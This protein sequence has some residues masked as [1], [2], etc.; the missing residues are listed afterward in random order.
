MRNTKVVMPVLGMFIVVVASAIESSA[1]SPV[2]GSRVAVPR[3]PAAS[4]LFPGIYDENGCRVLPQD[5]GGGRICPPKGQRRAERR[6]AARAARGNATVNRRGFRGPFYATSTSG[7]GVVVLES[8]VMSTTTGTWRA[9]GLLRNDTSED[10]AGIRVA[11]TLLGEGGAVLDRAYAEVAVEPLRPGEP[12]PFS[13]ISHERAGE[14]L[15]VQWAVEVTTGMSTRSRDLIIDEMWEMPNL[16]GNDV[17]HQQDSDPQT[18]TLAC[19]YFN[20]GPPVCEAELVVAWLD[21]QQRVR[22]I[23]SARQDP[24]TASV[25]ESTAGA[26]FSP[27]IVGDDG[28]GS[29]LRGL[30]KMYWLMGWC[31]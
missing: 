1:A 27:I 10:A 21:D 8:T 18:Y 7:V 17:S 29:S 20:L 28:A 14:V 6:N 19:G 16:A 13:L 15:G 4:S 31:P 5:E 26:L 22:W 2:K 9:W 11:A 24:Q 12:A 30:K 3:L 25:V 23:D